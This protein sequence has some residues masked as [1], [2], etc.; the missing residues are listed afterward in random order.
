MK[1]ILQFITI[2]LVLSMG[3]ASA[4]SLSHTSHHSSGHHATHSHVSHRI[5]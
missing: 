3:Q 1:Y 2:G 5:H 4:R